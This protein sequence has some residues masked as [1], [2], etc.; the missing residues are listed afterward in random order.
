MK[1]F[2]YLIIGLVGVSLLG[3]CGGNQK[4]FNPKDRTSSSMSDADRET[5]I[6]AMKSSLAVDPYAMMT[7]NDVKLTVMPPSPTGDLNEELS[8]KI[9]V[10]M[11]QMISQNGIGGL[12]TVPGFALTATLT[13]GEKKTTGTAPQK[14]VASY[15]INYSVINT[16]TGDVYASATQEITGVGN[17]FP[18]ATKNAIKE[19][20]NSPAIQEM[21][22][23]ASTKI[24]AWFEE[25]LETFKSQVETACGKEDYALA[26]SLIESVPQ[27]ATNAFAYAQ[28]RRAD[29]TDK[30]QAN[31]A[32][33][34]LI[35]LKQAIQEADGTPSS[36]VY[37][38]LS[39]LPKNSPEYKQAMGLIDA[40][41]SNVEKTL[42]ENKSAAAAKEEAD[43]QRAH[44]IELATIE[45]ERLK[46]KYQ[47]K[48]TEQ[49]LRQ[50][51]RDK[52]D[53]KRGFW[54]NLGARIIGAID[55]V[56]DASADDE[57]DVVK[58]NLHK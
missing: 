14:M 45:A 10:K 12:N 37:A 21:L 52:D 18:Q 39:L 3:S 41:E 57:D 48:A 33:Q 13:N 53:Q 50:H 4:K 2:K 5:A 22:A 54:G 46:A 31:I 11:L 35:A 16:V 1:I 29:V 55:Q 19:I 24:I 36:E 8:E 43:A 38:H 42:A 44:Q 9:A 34:E 47:A 7:S 25:N 26:L 15:T 32:S 20:K 30:F 27:K 51:M 58:N 17:S 56:S 28:S 49:A 40:Y 23:A 6:N